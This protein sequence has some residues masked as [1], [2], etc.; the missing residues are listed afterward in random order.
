V[1]NYT[2]NQRRWI[3]GGVIAFTVGASVAI[4]L[5]D[6]RPLAVG[7]LLFVAAVVIA[8]LDS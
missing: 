7:A 5:L 6:W 8:A 1:N 2:L 4:G 3:A